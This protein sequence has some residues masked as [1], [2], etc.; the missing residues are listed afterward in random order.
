MDGSIDGDLLVFAG[1]VEI[2]GGARITGDLLANGGR[3]L[4]NG[5]VDGEVKTNGGVVILNGEVGED[6]SGTAGEVNLAGTVGRN[7]WLK[8]DTLTVEPDA[9][10]EGDLEYTSRQAVDLEGTGVVGGEIRFEEKKEE[11]VK[12]K[13][14]WFSPGKLVFRGWLFLASLIV[15]MV[16]IALFRRVLPAV[17]DSVGREPLPSLGIGFVFAV[18]LPVGAGIIGLLIVTLP[19]AAIALLL[20]LIALYIAKLPVAVWL[21]RSIVRAFGGTDPSPYLVLPIGLILLYLVFAVPFVGKLL[22]A[23]TLLLGLGAILLG[24]RAHLREARGSGDA[25]PLGQV[26][27]SQPPTPAS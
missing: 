7:V 20:W 10:I 16:A 25:A 26:V 2:G 22:W 14:G 6:L 9:R 27:Q 21:G 18:V 15:G 12:R 24:V 8:C 13:K 19:L 4:I 3:V 23:A 17:V 1:N 5:R 11:P